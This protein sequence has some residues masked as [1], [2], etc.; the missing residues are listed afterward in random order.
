MKKMK[1]FECNTSMLANRKGTEI[2]E[3]E[4][5]INSHNILDWK[6]SGNLNGTVYTFIYEDQDS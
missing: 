3:L 6:Q 1:V 4:E 2:E 5:F